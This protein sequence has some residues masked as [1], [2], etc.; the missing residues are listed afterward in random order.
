MEPQASLIRS[1]L[2]F[3]ALSREDIA[4]VLGKMEEITFSAGATIVKQG[5]QG[6]AFYL[7]QSGAVQVVV[8][9]GAGNA[10]IVAILG[11]K[12]WFG[13]MALL[14][15]EPR[16]ATINTVKETT[17]WRLSREAWDELIDKHPT[18]LL[19]FC[20][21]LSKRLSYVDRQY[22]TGR[23]AFNSLAEEFYSARAPGEQQF[24]RHASLLGAIDAE[25]F[26]RLFRTVGL[27]QLITDLGDSQFPLIRHLGD[28]K[29]ELHSFFKD[30]LREKLISVD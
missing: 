15:G 18:W 20:A 16:S 3:S 26:D 11:A 23:E 1:I 4:K 27:T 6:D 13:E 24:F 9:S 21:T 2:I 14:S 19:Q 28:R 7:I 17:L 8:D 12:D 22:S 10:E 5:D 30:F 29:Y 25:N